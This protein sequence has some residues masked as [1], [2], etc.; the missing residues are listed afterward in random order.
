MN[1]RKEDIYM[2]TFFDYL[3]QTIGLTILQ[4]LFNNQ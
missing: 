2:L 1:A 3:L 4:M